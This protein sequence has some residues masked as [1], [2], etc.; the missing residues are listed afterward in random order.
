MHRLTAIL[1]AFLALVG[2][3]TLFL[4]L[5]RVRGQ[6][7]LARYKSELI[8]N[9]EKL[10]FGELVR[11]VPESENAARRFVEAVDQLGSGAV[12]PHNCPPM[13]KM[14]PSGRAIV[15]FREP[16][17]IEQGTYRDGEWVEE[18]VTNR[19][20]Q[21]AADLQTNAAA[22]AQ[23]R[24]ALQRPIHKG[25][26]STSNVSGLDITMLAAPKRAV[27]WFSA[28]AMSALHDGRMNEAA[29]NL[30]A[31]I[32]LPSALAEG[33]LVISELVRFAVAAIAGATTWEALQ[34]DGWSDE[35][36]ARLQEAWQADDFVASMARS[37]DGERAYGQL[38]FDEFRRSNR[39]VTES[40]LFM[41]ALALSDES[42]DSGA[43]WLWGTS[44]K[45][46]LSVYSFIWRFAWLDQ[47]ER[48][49]L[50]QM[51]R[52][53]EA[54]RMAAT[55][56]SPVPIQTAISQLN[57]EL[58]NKNFYDK[59]RYPDPDPILTIAQSLKHA[60]RAETDRA[61]TVCAIALKRYQ[62]SH[63]KL[64]E[65]LE[66]LVPEF[67]SAVPIDYMD[68]KPLKYRLNPDGTF[69]LYSV[70]EDG[71]DNGADTSP[72]PG[73]ER[74]RRRWDRRDVVWPLPALPEEIEA[75]RK[76]MAE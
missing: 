9:G 6:A 17:W 5:E 53:I 41:R 35:A 37:L 65:S 57:V 48:R 19:W 20:E 8:A 3:L 33:R 10:S 15:G 16:E 46:A 55:N 2:L 26:I 14:R 30:V 1:A 44:R 49:H 28:A 56:R 58:T 38:M 60:L 13:M 32:R 71:T 18:K 50:E 61:L 75:Y 52:L 22:L 45:P 59:L 68:G 21:V 73:K 11:T 66:A 70:G 51:Q 43:G 76:E 27:Q 34:A 62:L 39:A 25:L 12:L 72:L 67:L 69:V 23:I 74:S 7:A 31:L 64:P 24:D 4:L 40:L 54:A 29:E 47:A 36:L 42:E 63:G